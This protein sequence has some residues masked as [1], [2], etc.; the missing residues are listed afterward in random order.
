[1]G[2]LNRSYL[3]LTRDLKDVLCYPNIS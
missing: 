3:V 2:C 1:M